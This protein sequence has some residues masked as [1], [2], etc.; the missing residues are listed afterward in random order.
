MSVAAL[1]RR[2]G[3]FANAGGC[4]R[5]WPCKRRCFTPYDEDTSCSRDATTARTPVSGR[6]RATGLRD[7]G[8][9]LR[10]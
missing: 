2:G 9:P 3:C 5:L 6:D 7:G 4:P 1:I 8:C 10:I